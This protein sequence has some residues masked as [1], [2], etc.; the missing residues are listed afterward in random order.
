MRLFV[1]KDMVQCHLLVKNVKKNILACYYLFMH[2]LTRSF[3]VWFHNSH[4]VSCLEQFLQQLTA[5]QLLI[6]LDQLSQTEGIVLPQQLK[7]RAGLH[8]K[9][10]ISFF[11]I[12]V[13]ACLFWRQCRSNFKTLKFSLQPSA[14]PGLFM[15]NAHSCVPVQ[16]PILSH[17]T[18]QIHTEISRKVPSG[19]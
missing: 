12:L 19:V 13:I 6:F 11:H 1:S 18:A 16:C 15:R 9:T 8:L 10:R 2:W 7:L 5:P 4:T 3:C 14:I 17:Q